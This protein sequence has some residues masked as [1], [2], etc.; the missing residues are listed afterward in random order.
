[1]STEAEIRETVDVL[2]GT[3]AA[4]ALLHCQ[5][6]YPAPFK[7]VNLRYLTRLAEIGQCPVGYSGH[8]R[9]FHVPIAAVAL[10]AKIVEKHF[11]T[12]RDL[13]GN[14]HKVSL[15][16]DEFAEMVQ[17]IRE[18]EEALGTAAPRAVST[19]EMMNR[20]N[21]A[22]T[23]VAARRIEVG[24]TITGATTSTSRAP[25]A[26]CSPTPSTGSS[27]VPRARARG[28]R[29]LLRHR[30]RRG[31]ARAAATYDFRRPWGLPS[32]TTTSTAMSG[33]ATRTSSSSTSPTRTSTST[34]RRGL[35]DVRRRSADGLHDATP[36][37]CSPA[38]S[39]STSP[40]PTTTTGS[41][42]SASSS[43]SSTRPATMRQHFTKPAPRA[44]PGR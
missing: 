27:A 11:T 15:L 5:S 39:C 23:L 37:T 3:G 30:P 35:R 19:G 25:A 32:A 36:P 28:R 13:E 29:L 17:R 42:R 44:R 34:R 12:D 2:R 31:R 38:T 16:P 8:E 43:A 40:P 9:G 7:D 22:K 24:E 18:V 33:H 20:V 14:D 10:G 6:T 26:A 21:L 1:M 4:Y 41:A